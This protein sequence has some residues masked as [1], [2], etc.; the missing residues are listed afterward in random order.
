MT[1]TA[2]LRRD[3]RYGPDLGRL[4]VVGLD[5]ADNVEL[6]LLAGPSGA[7]RAERDGVVVA[8]QDIVQFRA[9]GARRLE[10]LFIRNDYNKATSAP[11]FEAH[12][13]VLGQNSH[14]IEGLGNLD[15]VVGRRLTFAA[16]PLPVPGSSGSPFAQLPGRN[17][18]PMTTVED[19]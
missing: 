3:R 6:K 16:L 19:R 1:R 18:R 8:D 11:H 2:A 10:A 7:D 17:N 14:I 5:D 15:Q 4:A 12:Q 9:E 13:I